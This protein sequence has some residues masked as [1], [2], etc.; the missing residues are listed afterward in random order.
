[1]S[2]SAPVF[3]DDLFPLCTSFCAYGSN[4]CCVYISL[5]A[6]SEKHFPIISTYIDAYNKC[7]SSSNIHHLNCTRHDDEWFAR[8]LKKYAII[9]SGQATL[10]W[11]HMRKAGGTSFSHAIE[12]HVFQYTNESTALFTQ[13]FG[14]TI[15]MHLQAGSR[16]CVDHTY[17]NETLFVTILRHPVDRYV[18][19]YFYRSIEKKLEAKTMKG[20]VME[21]YNRSINTEGDYIMM[22]K[23]IGSFIE[24][25]Q[26][27]WYTNP[28]HCVDLDRP[29]RMTNGNNYSY[30]HSGQRK[31]PRMVVNR[32]DLTQ[33]KMVLD[34]FDVVGVA[35]FFGTEE[36][37][38]KCSI[39]PWLTLVGSNRPL[40]ET[41]EVRKQHK[42]NK[43]E[44]LKRE[45]LKQAIW[46]N[47]GEQV[48]L[49]VELFNFARELS[50]RR[51]AISCC[52]DE[53]TVANA[54]W[55]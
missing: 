12:S 5:N 46:E 3:V 39:V 30:W 38:G 42:V 26:T 43:L 20:R 51:Q 9:T 36:A 41:N 19:E 7:C 14:H 40:T 49:D 13:G 17:A 55:M 32:R 8:L 45:K 23:A 28:N 22:D 4:T 1:V 21:W 16:N 31:D 34:K 33:A 47:L 27:R 35:P 6:E 11:A 25:W 29:M 10:Y 50:K 44:E 53:H 37:V 52:V 18:S 48:K 54:P 2:S 24:N 15:K